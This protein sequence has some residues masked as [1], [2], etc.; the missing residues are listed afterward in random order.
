MRIVLSVRARLIAVA[1]AAAIAVL[2]FA[3]ITTRESREGEADLA[4]LYARGLHP[5][6]TLQAMDTHLREVRF[7][8][9]AVLGDQM[10]L[11]GSLD[12]LEQ[13]DPK[14]F[15]AWSAYRESEALR[16]ASDDVKQVAARID[17][18]MTTLRTVLDALRSA[19]ATSN[20]RQIELLLEDEWP[21]LHREVIKPLGT[22]LPTLEREAAHFL[23]TTSNARS[24]KRVLVES[25]ALATAVILLGFALLVV[26]SVVHSLRIAVGVAERVAGGRFET[27]PE[28]K[29]L[30]EIGK[31]L[32]A[33]REMQ[34]RIQANMTAQRE[35]Q[36]AQRD[37]EQ[38]L[39]T[40]LEAIDEGFALY[41]AADRLV[42]C[43]SRYREFY[44]RS[45]HAMVPGAH[46]QEILRASVASG[47]QLDAVGREE[48]WIAERLAEHHDCG[49][50]RDQRTASGRHLRVT[51]RR[52]AGGGIVTTRVD[53]TALKAAQELAEAASV[54]K[55]QF[56]ATMSHEIRTPLNGVLGMAEMLL[57]TQLD[58]RQRRFAVL[59]QKS[60]NALLGIVNDI[61]DFATI[62]A[63]RL[64]IAR[65]EMDIA[66]TAREVIELLGDGARR[67]G[68]LLTATMAPDLPVTVTGDPLRL[69]Q[70]LMN[71]VGNAIKFTESGSVAV[72]VG[73]SDGDRS[74]VRDEAAA[75]ILFRVRDTGIGMDEKTVG[76]LFAAFMQADGSMA[77]R[78]GGTGLGLAISHQLVAL[79]GGQIGVESAP[80]QGSSFWF[81][82]PFAVV[83]RGATAVAAAEGAEVPVY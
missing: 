28:P 60:G 8:M 39:I 1:A 32:A 63:G 46:Y 54:A 40:A 12:H 35:A 50:S 53:V 45:A 27:V 81:T 73:F 43:N 5:V 47:Q 76:R 64:E 58:D 24:A 41:D 80:G 51:E 29:R 61:L 30:D 10:P 62:E 69:Q 59:I 49:G 3:G 68:L 4:R 18:G 19:Y 25:G 33:L 14:I 83:G 36:T 13:F 16:F 34:D 52:T 26:R 65:L 78:F 44:P 48:A 42:I 7:R 22:L 23:E 21:V 72:E 55:S 38:R 74:K 15:A 17:A 56:L 9:A 79:M 82:V 11:P 70:V 57:G 66:A 6:L 2:L 77:R 67:K 37:S 71:L 31:L 75:T 20:L